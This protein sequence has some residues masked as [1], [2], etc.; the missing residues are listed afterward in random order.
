MEAPPAGGER[1]TGPSRPSVPE[2]LPPGLI[3][4]GNSCY[5]NSVLQVRTDCSKE[6]KLAGEAAHKVVDDQRG[7]GGAAEESQCVAAVCVA[8]A[9]LLLEHEALQDWSPG[10]TE[11]PHGTVFQACKENQG[12]L[13][14]TADYGSICG[15]G[16]RWPQ[17]TRRNVVMCT[18]WRSW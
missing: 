15:S 13:Q 14:N 18:F 10:F 8:R 9:C 17:L 16:A 3:N 1:A 4:L 12:F 7:S 5:M 6:V 2:Q 11:S